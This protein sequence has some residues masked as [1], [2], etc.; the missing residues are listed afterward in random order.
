MKTLL[1]I[2]LVTAFA[3]SAMAE[4]LWW[5]KDWQARRPVAVFVPGDLLPIDDAAIVTFRTAG[6]V[7]PDGSDIR[8]VG[9]GAVTPHVLYG[10]GPGDVA[11]IAFKVTPDAREYYIYF[12]NP[13]APVPKYDWQPQRGLIL[14]TRGYRGGDPKNLRNML[15]IWDDSGPFFGA[16]QVDRV[17]QGQNMFGPTESFV[18]LYTGWI[19]CR[20]PGEYQFATSSDDASFLSVDDTLVVAW[21]GSHGPVGDAR[22]NGKVLLKSGLHKLTYRHVNLGA[23]SC[24][25]A[26]WR[27]PG[28][29]SFDIIPENAF[30]PLSR[31]VVGPI[32][33]A[34]ERV[35]PDFTAEITGEALMS[36]SEE[37]Y[38]VETTFTNAT[39]NPQSGPV[40]W[41]FG[42]GQKG[43]GASDAHVYL[44]SQIYPVTMRLGSGPSAPSL[45]QKVQVHEHWGWQTRK[46]IDDIVSI[47][48]DISRYD[49]AKLDTPSCL[50]LLKLVAEQGSLDFAKRITLSVISRPSASKSDLAF[51]TAKLREIAGPARLAADDALVAAYVVAVKDSSGEPKAALALA[52]SDILLERGSASTAADIT[53]GALAEASDDATRRRLYIA[54]ADAARYS[55]DAAAAEN[56]LAAAAAVPLERNSLQD[57]A[58]TGA[59]A[60]KAEDY[61]AR[62]QYDDAEQALDSWD[63]EKPLEKLEGYSSYLRARLYRAQNRIVRALKECDAIVAVSPES[64]YAPKAL[65]LAAK[66]NDARGKRDAARDALGKIVAV[67]QASPEAKEA[68]SMLA[69]LPAK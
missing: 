56:A 68:K 44:A 41:D 69:A 61:I 35:S 6:R 16:G 45:T 14:Q 67:Y 26:A 43:E 59:L 29:D 53:K 52:L 37:I 54:F 64:A 48:P 22:H 33:L 23:T 32:A 3:A 1:S 36:K 28:Q 2:L 42:D 13:S 38:A 4:P 25:V 18:S 7:K 31:A 49:I 50:N 21:P 55:G 46:D 66:I 60:F 10:L 15:A 47:F 34:G 24:A 8:V 30:V 12:G 63:W 19:L 57:V 62:K 5:D 39:T 11:T 51:A 40:Y 9:R 20:D 65:L 58:L 17:W 27:P